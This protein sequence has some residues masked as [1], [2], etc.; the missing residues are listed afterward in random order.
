MTQPTLST[1]PQIMRHGERIRVR[2]YAI[3][4]YRDGEYVEGDC[5]EFCIIG[6]IQP[7][8]GYALLQVPEGERHKRHFSLFTTSRLLVKD[9]CSGFDITSTFGSN[10]TYEVMSSE[11]WG[12]YH[13]CLVKLQDGQENTSG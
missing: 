3:G 2:R 7:V 8:T 12:R 6:N 1:I 5:E 11:N 13:K 4:T 9:I 10:L